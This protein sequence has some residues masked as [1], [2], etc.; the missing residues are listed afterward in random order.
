MPLLEDFGLFDR[1]TFLQSLALLVTMTAGTILL[2]W[3]GELITEYGIGNGIS[4]IIFGGI[5]AS[6]PSAIGGL[7]TDGSL[8]E[9]IIGTVFFVVLGTFRLGTMVRYVPYPVIGGFLAGTGLLLIDGAVNVMAGNAISA[10]TLPLLLQAESLVRW[11]PGLGLGLAVLVVLRRSSHPLALP[12]LLLAATSLFHI[13]LWFSGFP[14]ATARASGWLLGP[15]PQ[16]GLWQPL[17]IESL[18]QARWDVIVAESGTLT[19]LLLIA[20]LSFLLNATGLELAAQR[21]VELDREL[22][23][24]GFANIVSAVGGGPVGYHALGMSALSHRM[25]PVASPGWWWPRFSASRCSAEPRRWRSCR[26]SCQVVC[27][28]SW[29]WTSS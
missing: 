16:E 20:L 3:M 29:A 5:I 23:V 24:V 14:A 25:T 1:D 22:K 11:L 26:P 9:N 15:F 28:C 18:Q 17:T 27:C 6:L 12:G 8:A 2:V 7:L 13:V 21:D 4:I 19:T 10:S